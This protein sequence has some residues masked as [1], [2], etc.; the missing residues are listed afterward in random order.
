MPPSSPGPLRPRAL[1]LL[2]PGLL[3]GAAAGCPRSAEPAGPPDAGV[4]CFRDLTLDAPGQPRLSQPVDC[5]AGGALVQVEGPAD[6]PLRVTRLDVQGQTALRIRIE[7]DALGRPVREERTLQAPA[8][9][10]RVYDRGQRFEFAT[11]GAE[12]SLPVLILTDL[13]EQ[14]RPVRTEKRVGA[15]V[16]FRV[17]RTYGPLGLEREV[18]A[19]ADGRVRLER[20]FT[21]EGS[22]RIERMLDGEGR[23]LL[24]R[25]VPPDGSAGALD[26]PGGSPVQVQP[27]QQQ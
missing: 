17:V 9:P 5:A 20:R 27:L 12:A 10:L 13:D 1:A 4:R 14:G 7:R 18:T 21:T 11:P 3:L 22:K 2:L 8:Q 19:E 16:E 24:E 23:Q 26:N 6:R 15:R 25:E